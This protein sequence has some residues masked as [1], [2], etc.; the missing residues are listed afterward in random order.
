MKRNDTP[1]SYLCDT[2]SC[3]T[4]LG[5]LH[6]KREVCHF[7]KRNGQNR[8]DEALVFESEQC[9]TEHMTEIKSQV[10]RYFRQYGSHTQESKFWI[11]FHA[12]SL[13]SSQFRS[14]DFSQEG[15]LTLDFLLRLFEVYIPRSI[16]MDVSDVNFALTQGNARLNDE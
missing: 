5:C 9:K 6:S 4:E 7:G 1:V 10:N 16:G 8:Q 2:D 13:D 14:S 15:G 11:S 3:N 12:D